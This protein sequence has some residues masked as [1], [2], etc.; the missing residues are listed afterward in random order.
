MISGTPRDIDLDH[1]RV[2][3][4][5]RPGT[6]AGAVPL[7]FVHGASGNGRDPALAFSSRLTRHRA[8]FVDRPGQG[9]TTRLGRAD[10]APVTQA[11]VLAEVLER[12]GLARAVVIGHSWGGSVAAALAVARPDLVAGLVFLAP[13]THPWPGGVD[14]TYRIATAPLVGRL[15]C[16]LV[17]PLV[18][19]LLVE[20]AI[21]SVFAPD[22]V[23]KNY[24][25]A[26]EARL[27]L[28]P[29][30]FRANAEDVADLHGHVGRLCPRYRE[31]AVPTLV[32]TGD[33]DP[34]V[35]R[36]IHSAGLAR[37]I[38]GARLVVLPGIGH[39]PHH[40]ATERVVAEIAALV[41]RVEADGG[42][43]TRGDAVP[44]EP[45]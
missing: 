30:A 3:L 15:F 11:G 17:A 26:I 2:R 10:A 34:I 28:R 38:A 39:M 33:R 36:E 22:P 32:V 16:G 14:A 29:A 19:P 45:R 5:D 18:G 24:G 35:L 7:L 4:I 40:A 43:F 42:G 21:R 41:E 6:D 37:D 23:P 31:I 9:G 25:A 8:V 13:A 44:P 20:R 27:L 12:L 1:R